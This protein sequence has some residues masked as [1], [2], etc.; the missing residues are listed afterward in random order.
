MTIQFFASLQ[1][2]RIEITNVAF[3]V[4]A[5]QDASI[6]VQQGHGGGNIA[7]DGR[8]TMIGIEENQLEGIFP[9]DIQDKVGAAADRDHDVVEPGPGNALPEVAENIF[10]T[11][12][13]GQLG[14]RVSFPPVNAEE[15]APDLP[16]HFGKEHCGIAAPAAD[17]EETAT[18]PGSGQSQATQH[19]FLFRVGELLFFY[20]HVRNGPP[21]YLL[22]KGLTGNRC[23]R[24]C[25]AWITSAERF[26]APALPRS[27]M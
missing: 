14:A 15:S 23:R 7:P 2:S 24:R 18:R 11:G 25:T 3:A 10:A 9:Q 16:K 26:R 19:D 4:V 20:V 27:A 8:V 22:T 12:N 17:F 6:L 21:S 13:I 1:K 5:A